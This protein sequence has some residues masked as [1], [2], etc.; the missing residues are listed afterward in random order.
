MEKNSSMG[1][2]ESSLNVHGYNTAQMKVASETNASMKAVNAIKESLTQGMD[3]YSSEADFNEHMEKFASTGYFGDVGG[4]SAVQ[5]RYPSP[6]LT[7]SDLKIPNSS[8]DIF[9]WCKYSYMFDP[10]ICGAINALSI[11]PVTDMSFEDI[12][13]EDD[14]TQDASP[15]EVDPF[16]KKTQASSQK[17]VKESDTLKTYRRVLID[18]LKL[19]KFLVDIGI[20]YNTYGNCFVFGEFEN[21]ALTGKAEWKRITRLNPSKMIL[22]Y[23][24]ATGVTTYK[25]EVPDRVRDIIKSK[26]PQKEYDSIPQIYKQAVAK[27][28]AVVLNPNNIYHFSRPSDSNGND[29][30][31]GTPIVANVLKLI[32]YR[33][34]LRQ[35]Q[36][37]IAREHIVPFRI[38]YLQ[39]SSDVSDPQTNWSNVTQSFAAEIMKSV[40]DPNYKVI[41]PCQVGIAEAGGNGRALMLTSEIE[42]IQS[43]ILAGMNVPREF[44]F[45]GVGYSG[46]SIALKIL[47]NNFATYRMMLQDFVQNFLIKGM[48]KARKEWI[49][50]SDD[51]KI[52]KVKF[53]DLKMM[54]DVQ[55]KQILINLNGAGKISDEFLLNEMGIDAEKMRHAIKTE[56]LAKVEQDLEVQK[57]QYKSQ[58]DL[59]VYQ[60]L[61]LQAYQKKYPQIF[62][63]QDPN[64]QQ[65]AQQAGNQSQSVNSSV[66][67]QSPQN[68][69]QAQSQ[70]IPMTKE[71]MNIAQ[72]MMSLNDAQRLSV[73]KTLPKAIADKIQRFIANQE[74]QQNQGADM[75][76]M[77]EQRP[78]RRKT[79]S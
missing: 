9:E 26:K 37:A 21:N 24:A 25:M 39:P 52:I 67:S 71:E 51:D 19:Q 6:F 3:K 38:Y 48:A 22:D 58:L 55:K 62:A 46:G 61:L 28:E 12:E 63:Q 65:E 15:D 60:N 33:N 47:E 36:E 5:S 20:D 75:R 35:A 72:H 44:L 31:W 1:V 17:K 11:Y 54:D 7:L 43:E 10:L 73:Y 41:A 64:A 66:Q 29:T 34:I 23:N 70:G 49:N 45:G 4:T 57:M 18:K 40:K 59:Q 30:G 42:Q 79:L 74:N 69:P 56:Q 50:E 14:E 13:V 76:P 77:P 16:K 8:K 32:M 68:A 2:E 78:P 53:A 27:N